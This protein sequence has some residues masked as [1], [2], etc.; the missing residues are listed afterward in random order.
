MRFPLILILLLW[1]STSAA[2]HSRQYT[3][4]Q[5]ADRDTLLVFDGDTVSVKRLQEVTYFVPMR[6]KRA[7]D[8]AKYRYLKRKVYRVFKYAKLASDS[9]LSLEKKVEALRSKRKRRRAVKSL[10]RRMS[11]AFAAQLKNLSRTDGQILVKL[12]YRQT[13]LTPYQIIRKYRSGWTAFWWNFK[14]NLFEI[15]LKKIYDPEHEP[16]DRFIEDIVQK[17]LLSSDLKE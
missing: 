9:L 7:S 10:Q 5:N 3:V 16:E 1:G 17:G 11:A 4:Q 2:Q 13:Q 12:V 6:L 14:A 15:S 8:L